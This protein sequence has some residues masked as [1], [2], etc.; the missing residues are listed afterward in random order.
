VLNNTQAG[1]RTIKD[2]V[3][4]GKAG[5]TWAAARVAA[6]NNRPPEELYDIVADPDELTNL[7]GDPKLAGVKASLRAELDRWM[8]HEGDKGVASEMIAFQF[9]NPAIVQWINKNYPDA[10]RNP[11]GTKI[12]P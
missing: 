3:A 10:A 11:D 2:W 8:S 9:I 5:N 4:A 1:N 7:A 12:H 6:Y